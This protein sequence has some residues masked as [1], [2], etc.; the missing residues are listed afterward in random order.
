[1]K[2]LKEYKQEIF[3]RSEEKKRQI[4]KRRRIAAAVGVPLCLCCV[5]TVALFP[6]SPMSKGDFAPS[7]ES[8]ADRDMVME[9]AG[10]LQ[11]FRVTDPTEAA[12]VLS[13]LKG[14]APEYSLN[15][16]PVQEDHLADQAEPELY[17]LILFDPEGGERY[18]RIDGREVLC[19]T[20]AEAFHLTDDQAKCL[21][22]YL[23]QLSEES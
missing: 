6:G 19:Q 18:Y 23:T 8:A 12:M 5:L 14:E 17:A 7:M 11:T 2:E 16:D 3:R 21:Y 20:T 4:R 1:M 15:R 13:I 22:Q 9:N 10:S